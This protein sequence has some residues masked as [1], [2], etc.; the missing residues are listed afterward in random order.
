MKYIK[1]YLAANT[2]ACKAHAREYGIVDPEASEAQQA[3]QARWADEGQRYM[4][5]SLREMAVECLRLDRQEVPVAVD[6]IARRAF[7]TA[8]M[9]NIFTTNVNARLV[10]AFNEAPDT[11]G[12][13]QEVD[14]NNF[15]TQE[16]DRLGKTAGLERLGRGGTAKHATRSDSK[17]EWKI[18]RYAKQFAVD[19]QDIVDDRMNAIMDMPMELGRSARRLRPDLVYSLLF[20]NPTLLVDA[21]A[22]FHSDHNN[23]ATPDLAEGLAAA[24]TAMANQR[25]DN[26]PLNIQPRHLLIPPDLKFTAAILLKSAQRIIASASGGTYNPLGD[27]DIQIVSESRL[28][29]GG[30]IDPV[31]G[32]SHVG[33]AT[34]WWLAANFRDVPTIKVGYLAGTNRR[35]SVRRFVLDQ[36]RWGIGWDI[37][38]DIGAAIMAFPGLYYSTGAT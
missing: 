17:E 18:G 27:E 10:Q 38:L 32:T 12:W 30:V 2:T 7:S 13:V 1:K 3:E 34:N 21:T 28:G 24:I 37:K 36:G 8:S 19:D 25:Q 16:E 33:L 15:Q 6:E 22:V 35:P 26:V 5:M 31:T 11:S 29:T 20:A 14:V 9:T 4:R 23:T